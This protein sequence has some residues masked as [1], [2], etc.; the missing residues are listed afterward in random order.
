MAKLPVAGLPGFIRASTELTDF[1][2]IS[3]CSGISLK[4][5]STTAYDGYRLAFGTKRAPECNLY[6]PG[7]KAH[8]FVPGVNSSEFQTVVIQLNE[9]SNCNS[10]STGEPITRCSADEQYCPDAAT[11]RNIQTISIWAEG[12]EGD[13]HLET[14]SITATGC[15]ANA[16]TDNTETDEA[17]DNSTDHS[18]ASDSHEA[19]EDSEE[20]ESANQHVSCEPALSLFACPALSLS[21]LTAMPTFSLLTEFIWLGG[22]AYRACRVQAERFRCCSWS[23]P[24]CCFVSCNRMVLQ[25]CWCVHIFTLFAPGQ[26]LITSSRCCHTCVSVWFS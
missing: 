21:A 26:F 2:D 20:S 11:L 22:R 25:A 14:H 18:S 15:S 10:D 13:V 8:F 23:C 3:T 6:S 7:F 5:K 12:V 19:T 4:V 24:A 16:T 1:P 17:E 9:F